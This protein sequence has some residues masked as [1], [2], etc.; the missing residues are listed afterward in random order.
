MSKINGTNVLLYADGTLIACERSGSVNLEQ[1]LPDASCK[2]DGGWATHINGL[3]NS[4]VD[5]EALYSTT[6][7]SAEELIAFITARTNIVVVCNGLGVP[8]AFEGDVSSVSLT[9]DMESPASISGSIKANGPVYFLEGGLVTA[10]TNGDY[11]TFTSAATSA[12]TSA[13]N[14]AGAAYANSNAIAIATGE[15]Y[16]V[17]TFLTLTSG[18]VPAIVLDDSGDISNQVNLAAGL[19][20][21]TLTATDDAAA[22]TLRI[23]NSGASNF[24]T[25]NIYVFRT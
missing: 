24:T 1:D 16:K 10:W 4:S 13:I 18:Q 22:G 3:R 11:D 8:F 2:E 5:F 19:N 12:I 17:I 9:A 6:G 15:V 23:E 21:I 20:V 14:A 25:S 7:L